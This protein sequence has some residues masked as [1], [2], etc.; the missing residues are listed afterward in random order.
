[1]VGTDPGPRSSVWRFWVTKDEIYVAARDLGGEVKTSLHSSGR[2]RHAFSQ[3]ARSPFAP[4]GDRAWFKWKE[5]TDF[6]KGGRLLIEIDVPTN[7]LTRPQ[8][9]PSLGDK[10]K[11]LLVDPAP[12]GQISTVSL[13]VTE[14]GIRLGPNPDQTS[15]LLAVWPTPDARIVWIIITHR[16]TECGDR[17]LVEQGHGL[18]PKL[19]ES[20]GHRPRLILWAH[21]TER[22]LARYVDLSPYG[23]PAEPTPG[24]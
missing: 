23:A 6:A 22:A 16:E 14:P 12:A 3:E 5:P 20:S 9:E 10:A 18:A 11:V 8:E 19:P 24:P 13:V 2:Y 21:D 15:W 7:E 17:L 4:S 1:M